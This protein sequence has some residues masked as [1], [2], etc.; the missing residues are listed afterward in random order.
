MHSVD[1]GSG[2]SVTRDPRWRVPADVRLIRALAE[3]C[4]N[5]PAAGGFRSRQTEFRVAIATAMAPAAG[6]KRRAMGRSR[7]RF[8]AT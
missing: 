8:A 1:R 4:L 5:Q 7:V 6:A 3:L 2:D